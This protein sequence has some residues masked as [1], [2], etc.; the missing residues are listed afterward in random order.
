MNDRQRFHATLHYQPR[1]RVPICDFGFWEETLPAWHKQGL[2][3]WV[4][5]WH[6]GPAANRYFGMDRYLDVAGYHAGLFPAFEFQVV[7]DQGDREIVQQADGVRVLRHKT[8][9]SIPMD[10]GHLLTDRESWEKHYKPR[11]D[12]SN[13]ERRP[14]DWDEQVRRLAAPDRG[15]PL[16]ING[17]SLY[18]CLRNW[19]GFEQVSLV[20]YDD[21]AWFEEMVTAVADCILGSMEKSFASGIRYDACAI[22]EDM[23]YNSGPL[24]GPC[25]FKKF[26]VP[27]Y[28]R[29][30]EC[31]RKNGVDV[32]WVDCDGKIDDLLPLWLDAGINCM[33]PIEIGTWGADPLK[34]RRQYGKELLMMGGFDKHLLAKGPSAI[35]SEVRRLAPLVEEG[36]YIPFCDH[37]VP[38]DVPLKNYMFYLEKVREIWGHGVNLKPLAPPAA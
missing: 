37:R 19:L 13:P 29:I 30:A 25:Q 8:M 32:I 1:D 24:L 28:R 4:E 2:P 10:V 17:G 20:V 23:C 31:C 9:S 34:F 33:F 12:P 14:S 16:N 26:L 22:W 36:G 21:P 35:E 7:E 38:P 3:A 27:H 5:G 18:G 11:L 15:T 6:N